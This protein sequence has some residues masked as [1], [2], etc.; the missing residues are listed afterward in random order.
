MIVDNVGRSC[1]RSN[2]LKFPYKSSL[3]LL[4]KASHMIINTRGTMV[5]QFTSVLGTLKMVVTLNLVAEDKQLV[6]PKVPN[7]KWW[8]RYIELVFPLIQWMP[9]SSLKFMMMKAY[10]PLDCSKLLWCRL[11]FLYMGWAIYCTP[12]PIN[13]AYYKPSSI[14]RAIGEVSQ[15]KPR[16]VLWFHRVVGWR[17]GLIPRRTLVDK[18]SSIKNVRCNGEHQSIETH[19]KCLNT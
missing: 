13:F 16:E 5:I 7:F 3:L 2:T 4:T 8:L 1:V 6:V 15:C 14:L 10:Q 19:S 17:I 11:S 9:N 12:K 18:H